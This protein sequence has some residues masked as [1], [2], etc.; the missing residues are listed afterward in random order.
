MGCCVTAN[1]VKLAKERNRPNDIK[2]EHSKI[3]FEVKEHNLLKESM[4]MHVRSLHKQGI[5]DTQMRDL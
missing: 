2:K 3:T 5:F 1:D 4:G